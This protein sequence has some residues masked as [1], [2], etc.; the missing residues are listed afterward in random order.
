MD[1]DTSIVITPIVSSESK[2]LQEVARMTFFEAFKDQNEAQNMAHYLH[3]AFHIDQLKKE[4]SDPNI[5]YF[6]IT[7]FD[8]NQA[9]FGESLTHNKVIGYLK[10]NINTAQTEFKEDK[11][12][13]IERLYIISAFQNKKIGPYLIQFAKQQSRELHKH[14]IWLGVW[15]K[16][17]R[18][19]QFYKRHGFTIFGSHPYTL[20]T[21]IQ[22]DY[23]M[24]YELYN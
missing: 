18:A 17:E 19:I 15:Q 20:G 1:L 21:D 13:E 9:K 12:L 6:F 7:Y 16:N 8:Q 14:Y 23:L 11:G 2:K 5:L 22:T 4:L 10:F 24:K 3:T